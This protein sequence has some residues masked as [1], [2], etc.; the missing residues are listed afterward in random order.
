VL[1]LAA[2][3]CSGGDT[4]P[5]ASP[6][7]PDAEPSSNNDGAQATNLWQQDVCTLLADDEVAAIGGGLSPMEAQPAT[8]GT[9]AAED[10]GGSSCRWKLSVSQFLTLDVYPSA[11]GQLDELAAHDPQDNWT[12][13]EY[14]GI[15]GDAQTVMATGASG[16]ETP[17]TIRHS[18]LRTEKSGSALPSQT[19]TPHPLTTLSQ[20]PN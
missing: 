3:A 20:P 5:A 4:E 16:L 9:V 14:A 6:T 17:G 10:Y 15:G 19:S 1:T 7:T 8:Q 12:F 11:E 13:E 2:A 18:S